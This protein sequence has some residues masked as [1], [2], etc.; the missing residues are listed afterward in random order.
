[1][2]MAQR[3]FCQGSVLAIPKTPYAHVQKLAETMPTHIEVEG[4]FC[5]N[6]L[7][8]IKRGV[9]GSEVG[10]T[11]R[12]WCAGGAHLSKMTEANCHVRMQI[13]QHKI[14]FRIDVSLLKAM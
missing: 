1:M 3:M 11:F 6:S 9:S 5:Q 4:L 12:V 13:K 14:V 2:R 8:G 10:P 7:E